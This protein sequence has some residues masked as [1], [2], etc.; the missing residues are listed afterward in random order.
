MRVLVT[1]GSGVIG[2][3]LI[4]CLLDKGHQ[5]RLLARQADEAAREW[6]D[7]VE[8]CQADVTRPEQLEGVADGC[9]AV[10]HITGI[11]AEE[12]PDITFE[13]VNVGGTRNLLDAAA[14]AGLPRFVYISSLA[15]ERGASAYHASKREAEE[16]VRRYAGEWLIVRP[17][18]VY[19]PGDEVISALLRMVRT[20]P[21]IPMIGTGT[22]SFQP[23]WYRDLGQALARAVDLPIDRGV[24]E[25][26]GDEVTT[27]AA[28]L[29]QFERL[30][31]RS[32]IR[33]PVP[34][35]LAGAG[36]RLAELAGLSLPFNDSQVQMVIEENVIHSPEGNALTRVFEVT[37]T[38]LVGGLTILADVQPEQTPDEGV[39]G[40]ER[41]RFWTDVSNTT[42]NPDSLMDAFR[43]RVVELMPIEF[44]AEPGTPQEVVEGATLTAAL[45]LRGNI[46]I[47]VEEVTPRA[48]T[49]ATL[50][51]HPLA[52][53]VRFTTSAPSPGVVQFRVSVFARAASM[54]DWLALSAGGAAAQNTTWRTVV[55]RVAEMAGGESEGVQEDADVVNGRDSEE[56]EAWIADLITKHKRV[57][58]GRGE[59]DE[60]GSQ[61]GGRQAGNQ[62]SR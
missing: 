4:P 39:G 34:E 8:A 18:N 43:R 15:A 19:G 37:P 16:L 49:F 27:M 25:V 5:V 33:I 36:A 52:G 22:H 35:F 55:E 62:V 26:A 32:P 31:D 40:M 56:I 10:V 60:Q 46:Q 1:G 54:V 29:D 57:E 21:V 45:P 20:L 42:Y 59:A 53:V 58:H 28:V 17:G 3:G 30:T 14:R 50:R 2:E 23:I 24:Y 13:R 47:R 12:P 41:K 11:V 61:A 48:V 6:P 44:A 9:Q 51:G 7:G 38:P